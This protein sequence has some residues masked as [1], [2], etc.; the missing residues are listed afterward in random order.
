MKKVAILG[1]AFDPP[2]LGHVQLA[3][4]AASHRWN[5]ETSVGLRSIKGG[6]EPNGKV[7]VIFNIQA[8]KPNG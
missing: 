4:A 7:T 6:G 1:G 3:V 8:T 2:H 5:M